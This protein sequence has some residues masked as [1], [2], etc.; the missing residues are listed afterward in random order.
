M[1]QP[2]AIRLHS[3]EEEDL[4]LIK[5]CCMGFEVGRNSNKLPCLCLKLVGGILLIFIPML[6]E[7]KRRDIVFS[8]VSFMI[9]RREFIE[10]LTLHDLGKQG[11]G[12]GLWAANL[13]GRDDLKSR[14]IL[15][16]YHSHNAFSLHVKN[17]NV[18]LS[19]CL[20]VHLSMCYTLLLNGWTEIHQAW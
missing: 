13:I 9:P 11:H 20:S 16:K 18:C 3:K 12:P 5:V 15:S 6:F 2:A 14:N 1:M 17:N 10:H 7:K 4:Y 8:S 19:V